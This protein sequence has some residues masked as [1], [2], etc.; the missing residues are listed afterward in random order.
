MF[1]DLQKPIKK[2]AFIDDD[3]V[4]HLIFKALIRRVSPEIQIVTFAS[5]TEAIKIFSTETL[6]ASAIILDINMPSMTGWDFLTELKKNG[7][8]IPVY[9]LTSSDDR[10]DR[11]RISEFSNIQAYFLKPLRPDQLQVVIEN[12]FT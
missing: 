10:R 7:I 11:A 6:D 5:A 9:M 3:D 8:E 1:E 4:S 2:L 12:H